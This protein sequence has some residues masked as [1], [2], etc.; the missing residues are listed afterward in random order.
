MEAITLDLE[1]GLI[2]FFNIIWEVGGGV[3]ETGKN[4]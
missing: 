3:G 4:V 2:V 1:S